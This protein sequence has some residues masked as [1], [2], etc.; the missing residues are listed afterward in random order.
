MSEFT[1]MNF[2]ISNF[3]CGPFKSHFHLFIFEKMSTAKRD[4]GINSQT[5]S[6]IVPKIFPYKWK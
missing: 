5:Q 2:E 4:Y 6:G 1:I 3:N